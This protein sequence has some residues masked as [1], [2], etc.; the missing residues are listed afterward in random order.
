L[1]GFGLLSVNAAR[2]RVEV[3]AQPTHY[4]PRADA[5]LRSRL[6]GSMRGGGAIRC[7]AARHGSR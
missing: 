4:R 3:L 2:D 1:V 5:R 7:L 6:L